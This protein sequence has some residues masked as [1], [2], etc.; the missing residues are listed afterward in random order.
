MFICAQFTCEHTCGGQKTLVFISPQA[1]ST[2]LSEI[3]SLTRASSSLL[4]VFQ[5]WVIKE[6]PHLVIYIGIGDQAEVLTT[7]IQTHSR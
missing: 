7:S 5:L 2:L 6:P 1:Q 3:G 4:N